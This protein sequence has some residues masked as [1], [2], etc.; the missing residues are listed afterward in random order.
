MAIFY[1]YLFFPMIFISLIYF[2][3]VDEEK[4]YALGWSIVIMN[5]LASIIYI[6]FPVSTYWWRQELLANRIEGNFF[7][8]TMYFFYENETS[9]N[10][11]PSMHAGMSTICFLAWYRYYKIKLTIKTEIIAI[12]SLIIACG[13]IISTLFV[14]Q[15]YIIDEVVGIS[16]AYFVG[17]YI[18]RLFSTWEEIESTSLI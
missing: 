7:A 2:I 8:N 13:V 1:V 11:F 16:L 6:I 17:K 14:K 5:L 18:F 12:I 10:C 3:F 9:F 15:H 4:G